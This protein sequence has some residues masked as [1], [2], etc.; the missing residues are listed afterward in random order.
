MLLALWREDAEFLSGACVRSN[1]VFSEL[2]QN[3]ENQ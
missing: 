3:E 2:F 1:D